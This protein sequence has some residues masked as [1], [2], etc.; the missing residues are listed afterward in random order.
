MI[1][2]KTKRIKRLKKRSKQLNSDEM[3]DMKEQDWGVKRIEKK[4]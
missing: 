3:I 1:K 4:S 2:I